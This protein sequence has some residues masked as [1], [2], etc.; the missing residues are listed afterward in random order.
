MNRKIP[1]VV[2]AVSVIGIAVVLMNRSRTDP[3]ATAPQAAS[4]KAVQDREPVTEKEPSLVNPEQMEK[5]T[6]VP[7][8]NVQPSMRATVDAIQQDSDY[9]ERPGMLYDLMHGASFQEVQELLTLS[10][11]VNYSAGFRDDMKAAAFERWYHLDPAA[12]ILAMDASTLSSS[13]KNSRMEVFLEDWAHR[14]PQDVTAFLEQDQLTGVSADLTYGALVRGSAMNG[15]LAVVDAA[16]ARIEDP[17]LSYYALKSAARVLQRDHADQ[18]EDWLRTLP[19]ADQNTAI[20]E[21]AWMLAD[22]DI[23]RALVGLDQLAARGADE[24]PVT[25][26]RVA[27]KWA[28]NDPVQAANWMAVQDVIGEEREILFASVMRVWALKDKGAAIRWVES[29]LENGKIDEDFMNRVGG[30]L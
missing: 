18:F 21:S 22:K 17:K 6:D 11:D 10:E 9:K 12:A 4:E 28:E 2:A 30:R 7:A 1:V 24:L 5:G 14:S 26:V 29:L 25:R 23:E 27:V 15:N 13:R 8:N 19:D 16:L 3:G 20:A